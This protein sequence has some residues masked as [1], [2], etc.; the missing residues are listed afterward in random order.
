M[1][2]KI[3]IDELVKKILKDVPQNMGIIKNDFEQQVRHTIAQG[4]TKF[5]LVSREEFDVQV[6]V[7]QRTREKLEQLQKQVEALQVKWV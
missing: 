5:N 4:L 6:A 1:I 3:Q 2:N 7:L